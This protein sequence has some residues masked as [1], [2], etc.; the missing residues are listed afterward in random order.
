ML[1]LDSLRGLRDDFDRVG[2]IYAGIQRKLNSG[3]VG[4]YSTPDDQVRD[5]LSATEH[6]AFKLTQFFCVCYNN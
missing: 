4:Q 1:N 5:A 2:V 6:L 3:G